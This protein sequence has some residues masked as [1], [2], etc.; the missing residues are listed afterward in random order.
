MALKFLSK[1]RWHV[2]RMENIRKVAEAE[3]KQVEEQS[4]M[5]ELRREREEERELEAIRR[6][7]EASGRI[8]KQRP[9]LEFIYKT[10]VVKKT[11]EEEVVTREAILAN[12]R[13]DSIMHSAAAAEIA[14]TALP[15]VKWCDAL[16]QNKGEDDLRMREDPMAAIV[17]K[18]QHERQEAEERRELLRRLQERGHHRH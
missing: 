10:P 13:P 6:L 18:R 17:A 15:G 7:Q 12:R 3:A 1:K 11:S 5:A 8:P 16:K 2:R 14:A 9:R 4:R